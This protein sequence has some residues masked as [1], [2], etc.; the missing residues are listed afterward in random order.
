MIKGLLNQTISVQGKTG[1]DVF[2]RETHDTASNVKCRFQ[3]SPIQRL[4]P[5]G[6]LITIEAVVYVADDADVDIDDRV[7]FDSEDYKVYG[8]YQAVDG[9]GNTNHYKLELTKWQM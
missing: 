9:L 5:N 7:T 1:Y 3:K 6:S 8:K 2:G 4:L